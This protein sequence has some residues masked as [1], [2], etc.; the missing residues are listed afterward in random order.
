MPLTGEQF[1]ELTLALM[2]AF[3]RQGDL[4]IMVKFKLGTYLNTVTSANNPY[5]LQVFELV[6]WAD[7]QDRVDD[8]LTG[9]L[10]LN[11][12]NRALRSIAKKLQ[13]DEGAGDFESI[14]LPRVPIADVD[15][16]RTQMMA[17]ERAVCR[18]EIPGAGGGNV[19]IGTGFLV[20]GS[21]VI[22]NKHVIEAIIS[23][24]STT[25]DI[26]LRFD[27]K[28]KGQTEIQEGV[29]YRLD[30][31]KP[32]LETSDVAALDFSLLNVPAALHKEASPASLVRRRVVGSSRS[33]INSRSTIRFSSSNTPRRCR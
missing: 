16:W 17:T 33:H 28:M 1:E 14:V 21:V 23:A 15:L 5:K 9:A 2:A 18:V 22:T 24:G 19:G 20:G 3:P 4:D 25:A 30:S 26:V 10:N 7:A 8:L 12:R 6:M 29:T 13:L 11:E 31:T 32:I 27:Y